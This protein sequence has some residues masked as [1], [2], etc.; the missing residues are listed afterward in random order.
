MTEWFKK[1]YIDKDDGFEELR[2]IHQAAYDR[3]IK[4]LNK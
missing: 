2:K 4:L 3:Y 1:G